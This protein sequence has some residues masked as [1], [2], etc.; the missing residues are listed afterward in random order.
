M[1]SP[2]FAMPAATRSWIGPFGSFSHASVAASPADS[3]AAMTSLI[4]CWKSSVRAT[5]S[6]SQLTSTRM[7]C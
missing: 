6:D 3:I 2:I 7:P 1:F 5:K 4:N